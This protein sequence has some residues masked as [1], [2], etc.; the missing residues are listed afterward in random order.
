MEREHDMRQLLRSLLESLRSEAGVTAIEY[1]LITAL[2]A[3]AIITA[4]TLIG[5]DM[6]KVF[7]H[8]ATTL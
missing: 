6:T 8:V 1:G 7:T 2:I 3:V 5:T 4:I